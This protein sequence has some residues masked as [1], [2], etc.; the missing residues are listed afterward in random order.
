MAY[1]AD[2]DECREWGYCHQLCENTDGSYQCSC[3]PGYSLVDRS[4]CIAS[5]SSSLLLFFAHDHSVWRMTAQGH[6]IQLVANTTGA[7]GLDFHYRNNQ[8]YWSD[9]KTRKVYEFYLML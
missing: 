7:S 9:I 1:V 6:D 4:Q 2:R 5:N 8:L 3:M